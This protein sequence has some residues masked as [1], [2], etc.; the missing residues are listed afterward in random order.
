MIFN[1]H[2]GDTE[3]KKRLHLSKAKVTPGKKVAPPLYKDNQRVII[4]IVK[5]DTKIHK[6]ID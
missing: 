4:K 2:L 1:T 5:S 6:N 3:Y